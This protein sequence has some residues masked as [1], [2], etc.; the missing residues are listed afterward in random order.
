MRSGQRPASRAKNRTVERARRKPQDRKPRDP[1]ADEGMA[2]RFPGAKIIG[3]QLACLTIL[4][5]TCAPGA[6]SQTPSPLQ[7]W[8]Y[9]GGVILARLF[10]P[11]L[12]EWRSV[13]G[14]AGEVEPVYAGARA[15]RLQGGPVINIQYR[16][17]AFV[18]TGE[19]IGYNILRGDHYRFGAAISYDLGRRERDDY[20][21]LRGMGDISAAPAAKV[22]G[23][24][25]L[26][27]KFPLI[28]RVDARQIVGGAN[29]AV[30]DAGIYMPLPGSSK[31]FVM[32]AGPSVTFAT[33]RYL[34]SEFGVTPAQSVASG[35]RV[36]DPH[37][38]AEAVGVGF[39]ATRFLTDHWLLNLDTAISK[40][41]GSPDVSPV[42]ERSTQ[43]VLVLS[44]N[45]SW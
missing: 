15:Y 29:G 19:G 7:E 23:S 13:A 14:V 20:T 43:R 3:H 28:L 22:Y 40:L 1:K 37:A 25:V 26:S 4:L 10:E 35:H 33:H 5:C 11:N 38:G 41:K 6:F 39:S 32:F 31:K 34:Q 12:P 18:S 27:R 16:D 24:V 45:Y 36:F 17:I 42:T 21:N 9:S 8:Q 30:G 44:V 2:S